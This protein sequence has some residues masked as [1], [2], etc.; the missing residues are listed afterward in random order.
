MLQPFEPAR[1]RAGRFPNH[2][3]TAN[4]NTIAVP[5]VLGLLGGIGSGKS[6]VARA[7]AKHGATVLDADRMAHGVLGRPSV[8]AALVRRWGRGVLES[9]AALAARAFASAAD[10]RALNRIV[11]PA[12][13]RELEKELRRLATSGKRA[14]VVDAPLLVEAGAHTLCDALVFVH[15]PAAARR[16]RVRR[17]S[18]WSAA[19][20]RRRE[21]FQLPLRTKRRMARFVIDNS[22]H[23]RQLEPQVRHILEALHDE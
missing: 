18:G 14:V 20:L 6:A 9:R 12:V 11:H 10:A 13:R 19:E 16:E 7:F 4:G 17:R 23:L 5:P 1:S 21:R 8:R 3:L 2:E 15:A 22:K